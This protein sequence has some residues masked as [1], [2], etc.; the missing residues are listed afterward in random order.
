M[1]MTLCPRC[2]KPA[3]LVDSRRVERVLVPGYDSEVDA[4]E[5][6]IACPPPAGCGSQVNT[7]H[8]VYRVDVYVGESCRRG[9]AH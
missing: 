9:V 2:G 4:V 3:V 6:R 7:V 5:R 8:V 1:A